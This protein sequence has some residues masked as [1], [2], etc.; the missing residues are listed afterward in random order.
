MDVAPYYLNIDPIGT[1]DT[2]T[3]A[4]NDKKFSIRRADNCFWETILCGRQFARQLISYT[5]KHQINVIEQFE[6]F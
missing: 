3:I 6:N 2:G 5:F 1:A 4:K